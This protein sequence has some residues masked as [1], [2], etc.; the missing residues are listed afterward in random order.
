MV[1]G[2]PVN[3]ALPET[4]ELIQ[5]RKFRAKKAEK[6]VCPIP[7]SLQPHPATHPISILSCGS[8]ANLKAELE[9]TNRALLEENR[10]LKTENQLL[11]DH[12]LN[13]DIVPVPRPDPSPAQSTSYAHSTSNNGTGL[14]AVRRMGEQMRVVQDVQGQL[15]IALNAL[16]NISGSGSGPSRGDQVSVSRCRSY[17]KVT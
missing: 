7:T 15:E 2:R 14:E 17:M 8:V 11:R 13:P 9:A 5:Q 6:I 4:R 1:R 12:L 16:R 3:T 10:S